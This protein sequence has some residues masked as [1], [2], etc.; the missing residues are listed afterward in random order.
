MSADP[1][2]LIADAGTAAKLRADLE[3]ARQVQV[4]GLDLVAGAS[5]LRTAIAA[6]PATAAAGV[7]V[8][9]KLIV[10]AI[11]VGGLVGLWSLTKGE[12]P[13]EPQAAIATPLDDHPLQTGHD[14]ELEA[15]LA[16]PSE[17]RDDAREVDAQPEGGEVEAIALVDAQPEGSEVEAIAEVSHTPATTR[18]K[19]TVRNEAAAPDHQREAELVAKARRS[20]THEPERALRLTTKLVREFPSGLLAEER[21]A[22]AIRALAALGRTQEAKRRAEAFLAS[23][24]EGPHAE[25]I[26]RAVGL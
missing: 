12:K 22:I 23:H 19:P 2:P 25:A 1:P 7:S 5:R 16:E 8:T 18:R 11:A 10:G 26:R 13:S 3:L 6:E 4:R 21:D 17:A 14:D 24:G 9:G 15:A 20:L